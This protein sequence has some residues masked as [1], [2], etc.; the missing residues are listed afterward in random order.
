MVQKHSK[1][2]TTILSAVS[3]V[4]AL[5]AALVRCERLHRSGRLVHHQHHRRSH[6]CGR[7]ADTR[8]IHWRPWTH[9]EMSQYMLGLT[10]G[11]FSA[12]CFVLGSVL[13]VLSSGCDEKLMPDATCGYLRSTKP[14]FVASVIYLVGSALI[15][16]DAHATP[17]APT[18]TEASGKKRS[19]RASSPKRSGKKTPA[20]KEQ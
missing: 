14:V 5:K 15:A 6:R 8:P 1:V 11:Q 7:T 9:C 12:W 16:L 2:L 17:G 18:Q 10:S 13:F 19:S 20:K 3:S 4:C